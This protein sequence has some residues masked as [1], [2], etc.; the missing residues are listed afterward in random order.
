M[1]GGPHHFKMGRNQFFQSQPSDSSSI[2]AGVILPYGGSAAPSGYLLCDGSAV[3]RATYASLF[4]VIGTS[5]GSGDGSTTFNVPN[6][7]RRTMVGAGG[8]ASGT[9]SNT[10]GSTGGAE[11]VTLT[12]SESGIAAHTH[13]GTTASGGSHT[14]A[15]KSASTSTGAAAL[16]VTSNN[17]PLDHGTPTE[18]GGSHTH[19]FTTDANSST[20]ASSAHNNMQPSLVVNYIIKT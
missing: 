2:P 20:S 18:S 13:N 6:Q 7:Q 14:H 15:I 12:G 11:S 9:L 3:S 19:T 17:T 16:V 4:A 5:F 1:V 8:S 10:V